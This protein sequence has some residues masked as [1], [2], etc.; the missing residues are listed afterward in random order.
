MVP[1]SRAV[2]LVLGRGGTGLDRD[3]LGRVAQRSG[4]GCRG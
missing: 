1:A 4:S 2:G 3:Q